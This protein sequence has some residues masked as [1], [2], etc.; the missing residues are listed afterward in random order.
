M[1][2]KRQK[3][4]IYGN[5]L[6]LAGMQTSLRACPELQVIVLDEPASEAELLASDVSVV[7][8]DAAAIQSEILLT[9][10]Q[11][12]PDL[13]LMGIDPETHEVLLAGQKA[14]SIALE[15]ILQ[16]VRG[17]EKSESKS[18]DAIK[19]ENRS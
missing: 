1:K 15:Q 17:Q 6:M 19:K 3:V 11:A 18:C 7:I 13:L 4:L 2:Q 12:Q 14:G 8:Y 10:M 16:I 5:S 9:Q